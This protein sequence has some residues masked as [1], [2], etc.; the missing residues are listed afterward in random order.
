MIVG[1]D[2]GRIFSR[3]RSGPSLIGLVVG[4]WIFATGLWS[5]TGVWQDNRSW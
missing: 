4:V 2:S 5:D 1:G 3:R